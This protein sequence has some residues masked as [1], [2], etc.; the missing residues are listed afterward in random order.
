MKLC[1]LWHGDELSWM[2]RLCLTSAMEVGHQVELYS[3][4]NVGNV[5]R[6]VI[7][8]DASEV[9]HQ[10]FMRSSR[11]HASAKNTHKVSSNNIVSFAHGSDIFRM[12]LQQQE[13]GCYIDCDIVFLKP[14]PN[15]DFI[16]GRETETALNNAVLRLPANS[17]VITDFMA[18]VLGEPLMLSWWSPKER[19]RQ[20]YRWLRGRDL[21]AEDVPL[22][23]FGPKALTA[24]CNRY[25]IAD[26]AKPGEVFYPLAWADAADAFT[27][28]KVLPI[29]DA[30]V[31]VHLWSSAVKLARHM[32]P[33]DSWIAE[34]CRRL[35]ISDPHWST[36][37]L[38]A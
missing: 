17:P 18:S 14:I 38:A 9:M 12:H 30:T 7:S 6:G 31:G 20:R 11:A 23:W 13:R 2:E 25:G 28:G 36:A 5:P 22:K 32:R 27:P 8:K 26:K 3:Y 29:T 10:S 37:P 4:G 35:G 34:Q 16:F 33:V 15:E 21:K 24:L 19:M 1:A